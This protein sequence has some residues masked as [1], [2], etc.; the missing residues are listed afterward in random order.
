VAVVRFSVEVGVAEVVGMSVVVKVD[1]RVEVALT[2]M[3]QPY[4]TCSQHH[5]FFSCDQL[6]FR[7]AK[8]T[9]QSKGGKA[10]VPASAADAR[11]RIRQPRPARSQHHACFS[12]GQ[13]ALQVSKPAWQS[14]GASETD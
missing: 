7:F 5:R 14:Y 6:S 4:P 8:P 10:V 2:V 12:A 13:S 3:E 11:A 1:V 9:M